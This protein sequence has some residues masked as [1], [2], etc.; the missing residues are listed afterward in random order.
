MTFQQRSG[1]RYL[2][3][4]AHVWT[5]QALSAVP[6]CFLLD[7]WESQEIKSQTPTQKPVECISV[8][9]PGHGGLSLAARLSG[10]TQT[11]KVCQDPPET[12]C[13]AIQIVKGQHEMCL[14]SPAI[15]P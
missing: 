2:L 10:R 1:L 7:V 3:A 6:I 13:S 4:F 14:P 9:V 5:V 15:Y 8:G 12:Y 11:L